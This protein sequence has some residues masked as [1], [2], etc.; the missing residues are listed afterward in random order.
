MSKLF[1]LIFTIL[2]LLFFSGCDE[3]E[4]DLSLPETLCEK[5]WDS[6]FWGS[7]TLNDCISSETPSNADIEN[8]ID[9]E[10]GELF[11]IAYECSISEADI[12]C[13]EDVLFEGAGGQCD[14]KWNEYISCI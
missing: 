5:C 14:S 6:T 7:P 3:K 8:I 13:D 10:C 4:P 11:N 2:G 1:V 9:K 12:S